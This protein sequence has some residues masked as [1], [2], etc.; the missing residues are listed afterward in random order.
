MTAPLELP[1]AYPDAELVMMNIVALVPDV[2]DVDTYIPEDAPDGLIIVSRVG[3]TPDQYDVTDYPIL[4]VSCFGATR[5]AAW[6][7]Q[8]D[9]QRYVL[10]HRGRNVEVPELGGSV[11]V[12]FA[13]IS[14]GSSQVPDLEPDDR[15]VDATYVLGLRRQRHLSS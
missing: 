11:L 10:A 12:D 7:L 1:L 2:T 15:R 13:D 9:C 14:D 6:K 4:R 5:M 8:Q 3:G